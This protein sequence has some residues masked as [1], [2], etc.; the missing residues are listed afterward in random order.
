MKKLIHCPAGVFVNGCRKR[1]PGDKGGR[2]K[3]KKNYNIRE[4]VTSIVQ[5]CSN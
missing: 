2:P 3:L 5:K 1:R 4:K